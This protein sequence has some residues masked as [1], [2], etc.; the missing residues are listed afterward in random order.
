MA[1][2]DDYSKQYESL[3]PSQ[4]YKDKL[5]AAIERGDDGYKEFVIGASGLHNSERFRFLPGYQNVR[6]FFDFVSLISNGMNK[7]QYLLYEA[8]FFKHERYTDLLGLGNVTTII[9]TL[10][11][12]EEVKKVC[13]ELEGI[14]E[15]EGFLTGDHITNA[16]RKQTQLMKTA[17]ES[18]KKA[19]KKTRDN[20]KREEAS[21]AEA[22]GRNR[23]VKISRLTL[24]EKEVRDLREELSKQAK[25]YGKDITEKKEQIKKLSAVNKN[26]KV[27]NEQLKAR[28]KQLEAY[29]VENEQLT[30]KI[31]ELAPLF[32]M[33]KVDKAV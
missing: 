22:E 17:K 6:D 1:S 32:N 8:A 27:E 5:I 26:L 20:R 2:I 18:A 21:K 15:E 33:V 25:E 12:D 24:H 19:A 11:N 16:L 4:E 10:S 31:K 28:I 7:K 23:K 9:R 29:E 3:S 30:A 14:K 13:K